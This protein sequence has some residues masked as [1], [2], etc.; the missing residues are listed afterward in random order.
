[1]EPFFSV[2]FL[3]DP[4]EGL[5]LSRVLNNYETTWSL[6]SQCLCWWESRLFEMHTVGSITVDLQVLKLLRKAV[7]K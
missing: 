4:L 7:G 2:F 6:V 1:M 5:G 3:L